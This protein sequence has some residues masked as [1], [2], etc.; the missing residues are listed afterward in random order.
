MQLKGNVDRDPQIN[1]K[2]SIKQRDKT[3][4]KTMITYHT[5]VIETGVNVLLASQQ[6]G[7][8]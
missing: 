6:N 4:A 8:N 7:M 5:N 2:G 3:I 1:Y